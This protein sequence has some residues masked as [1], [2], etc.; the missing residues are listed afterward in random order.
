VR[1]LHVG[2]AQLDCSSRELATN[3]A[4]TTDAIGVAARLGAALVVLPELAASGYWLDRPTL[5][6]AA[7]RVDDPGPILSTWANQARMHRIAVVGGFAEATDDG[8]FN[9]A[10]V[11]GPDGTIAGTYQKLHLFG[12]ER[13]VFSPGG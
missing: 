6:S 7:E 9:S 10:V 13:A 2:L 5:L 11:I 1:R 8:L 4:T 12:V 3:I